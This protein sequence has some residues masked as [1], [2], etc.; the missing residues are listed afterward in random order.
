MFCRAH[1]VYTPLMR[2][3]V[4]IVSSVLCFTWQPLQR[5]SHSSRSENQRLIGNSET[6]LLIVWP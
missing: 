5:C 2:Q 4:L 1:L 6:I 3:S